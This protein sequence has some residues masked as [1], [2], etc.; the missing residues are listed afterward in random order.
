MPAC[1]ATPQGRAPRLR[2]CP[3]MRRRARAG[4]LGAARR[5]Q[6]REAREA[7]VSGG[8]RV[9]LAHP[10]RG[11]ARAARR[12]P[13]GGGGPEAAGGGGAGAR[14][15]DSGHLRQRRRCAGGGRVRC[16]PRAGAAGSSRDGGDRAAGGRQAGAGG[17]A[18]RRLGGRR[19]GAGPGLGRHRR[20]TRRQPEFRV[21]PGFREAAKPGRAW[22]SRPAR[23]RAMHLQRAAAAVAGAA[24]RPLDV[25]QTGQY[26]ARTGGASAV[27]GADA[28]GCGGRAAGD[29]RQ[30]DRTLARRA[31]L[32]QPRCGD[33]RRPPA[34]LAAL[35]GWAR[36]PVLADL[37][38]MRRRRGGRRHPGQPLLHPDPLALDGGGRWRG[39]RQ[40]GGG[41][42]GAR[43]PA[44]HR[45]IRALDAEA[46][47]PQRS[48]LPQHGGQHPR[49]P[50]GP[51][52]RP[53]AASR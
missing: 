18:A 24:V 37:G 47:R 26:S 10:C 27:A 12:R 34:R 1:T 13:R 39:L 29:R 16:R 3:R 35:C 48:V 25:R 43:Q 8:R 38:G 41:G 20:G 42:T 33:A 36:V 5:P 11:V 6:R 50:R 52:R 46:A 49:L 14:L 28:G 21:P 7:S 44:Q 9:D 40:P 45:R 22:H 51:R 30:D 17:E 23:P 4:S 15:R 32:R 31:V 2:F 19:R 53:R